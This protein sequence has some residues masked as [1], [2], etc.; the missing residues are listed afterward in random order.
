MRFGTTLWYVAHLLGKVGMGL[1]EALEVVCVGHGGLWLRRTCAKLSTLFCF[2]AMAIDAGRAKS[3]VQFFR[4]SRKL[5]RHTSTRYDHTPIHFTFHLGN[6][7]RRLHA[8]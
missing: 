3:N 7:R 6:E 2:P 5:L 1:Q 8:T 4:G